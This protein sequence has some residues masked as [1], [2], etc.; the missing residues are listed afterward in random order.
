MKKR[1]MT[2]RLAHQLV[3]TALISSLAGI[4]FFAGSSRAEIPIYGYKITGKI[5]Q[6]RE[7][8]VQGLQILDGHL[9]MSTGNYGQSK[10]RRY[11]LSDG[12]LQ[13]ERR[14]DNR[15]F[16]E[17]LTVLGERIYQL[18]W[19]SRLVLVYNKANLQG[20]EY[21]RIPGQGWGITTDGDKLIYSD[22]SHQLHYLSPETKRI[23]H[24]ISVTEN[25]RP[26][27]QINELE[28][29]DGQIWANIWQSNRIVMIDP[30]SGAVSAVINL[31]GLLPIEE[32]QPGTDVLN[33]IAWNPDDGSVWVTG[34]RWPWIYQIE[35][36]PPLDTK[37]PTE[38]HSEVT[39]HNSR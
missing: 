24:S 22:G 1:A 3:T 5:P 9:Y 32:R 35:L 6:A 20:L 16:A 4:I 11:R 15:L 37:N 29:I 36:I 12:A 7:N 38:K 31:Q 28:W 34:K 33:G 18:T 10:L 21:F 2:Y 23:T 25:G 39:K 27:S 13:S 30:K 17:G 14:V 19:K 26:L 8:F